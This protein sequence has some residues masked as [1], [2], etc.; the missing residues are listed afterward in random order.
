MMMLFKE[1][2]NRQTNKTNKRKKE[3]KNKMKADSKGGKGKIEKRVYGKTIQRSINLAID[4][5]R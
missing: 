2:T 4:C 1:Q 3:N 5:D